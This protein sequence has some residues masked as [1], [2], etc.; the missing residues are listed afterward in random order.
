MLIYKQLLKPRG[1]FFVEGGV[2]I[3]DSSTIVQ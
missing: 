2:R 3:L 1:S